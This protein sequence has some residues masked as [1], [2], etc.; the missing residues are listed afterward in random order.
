MTMSNQ[1]NK[2]YIQVKRARQYIVLTVL[3]VFVVMGGVVWQ[4]SAE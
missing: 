2:S 1:E 3:M 4:L